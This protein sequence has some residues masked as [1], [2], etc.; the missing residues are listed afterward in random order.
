MAEDKKLIAP[1]VEWA[2][3][4]NFAYL[5]GEWYRVLLELEGSAAS[6]AS[7]MKRFKGLIKVP[8]I[9]ETV[10]RGFDETGIT[11]CTATMTRTALA[12][13]VSDN[14]HDGIVAEFRKVISLIKRIELGPSTP[15]FRDSPANPVG[16]PTTTPPPTSIV[17]VIDDGLAF[18]H[19]RFRVGANTRF[20]YF[21]NQ[22]DSN[23]AQIDLAAGFGAGREFTEARIN[24]L[25]ADHTHNGLVDED[26][27]YREAGQELVARRIK[28]GTHVMDIARG[29][30]PKDSTYRPP[31]LIGVQLT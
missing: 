4:T 23:I 5:P 28:H 30:D 2:V 10:P 17:A 18:A 16:P 21:W 9:Y 22:D 1:Y 29:P 8:S 19:E 20:K 13:L 25:L 12:A 3:M 24:K 15:E 6:F 7:K 14:G 31:Y 26:A 11:F 27:L